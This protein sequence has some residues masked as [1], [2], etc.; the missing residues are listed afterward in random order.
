M[1]PSYSFINYVM[2]ALISTKEVTSEITYEMYLQLKTI[3]YYLQ[4]ILS[5]K[6]LVPIIKWW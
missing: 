1:S 4:Y 2:G 6:I 5:H 3:L